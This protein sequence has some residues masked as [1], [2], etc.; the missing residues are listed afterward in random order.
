MIERLTIPS[1]VGPLTLE[2]EAGELVAIRF[3]GEA[4]AAV[5]TAVSSP[6]A[7]AT[8]AVAAT[9]AP[10]TAAV[11]AAVAALAVS[12]AAPAVADGAATPPPA[13]ANDDTPPLLQEAARQLA[14]YF[15]G[16]R[17]TFDLPLRAAETPFR[18]R[19]RAALCEIPYGE[20]C[21]YGQLAA[22]IGRPKAARAVGMANH[23][24]PFPIV[25]PCHRVV[26]ASGALTGYAGGLRIK[27]RLLQLEGYAPYRVR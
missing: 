26:G 6:T 14:A 4:A 1:P 18:Q 8:P 5:P 27:E 3:G 13:A 10:A 22:R 9:A 7:P 11:S 24:N 17:R 23:C 15:A 25:V 2:A 21:S 12:A 19:V 16:G 20:V